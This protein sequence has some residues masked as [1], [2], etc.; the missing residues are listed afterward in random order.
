MALAGVDYLMCKNCH[1]V[2]LCILYILCT[3]CT[4]TLPSGAD[5]SICQKLLRVIIFNGVNVLLICSKLN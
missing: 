2:H 3:L 5:N 4:G 1:R